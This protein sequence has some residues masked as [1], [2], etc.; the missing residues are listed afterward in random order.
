[1][2]QMKEEKEEMGSFWFLLL[3]YSGSPFRAPFTR[4][5]QGYWSTPKTADRARIIPYSF[6][7]WHDG[8]LQAPNRREG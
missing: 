3:T 8:K 5:K 4:A 1:M 7:K 6:P 2:Q